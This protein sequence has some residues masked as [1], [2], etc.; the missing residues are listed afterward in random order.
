MWNDID[1]LMYG[2]ECKLFVRFNYKMVIDD[3]IKVLLLKMNWSFRGS[4]KVE[5]N[6]RIF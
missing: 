5:R 2:K 3:F 4:V 6:K 1:K